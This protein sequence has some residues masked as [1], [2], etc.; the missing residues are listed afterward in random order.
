[1]KPPGASKIE[2]VLINWLTVLEADVSGGQLNTPNDNSDRNQ[3]ITQKYCPLPSSFDDTLLKPFETQQAPG[4]KL[5]GDEI[6][7]MKDHHPGNHHHITDL[8]TELAIYI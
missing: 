7:R 8:H 4:D 5:A 3:I 6:H 2:L 1:M